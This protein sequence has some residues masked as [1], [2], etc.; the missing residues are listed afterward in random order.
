MNQR[1]ALI[2]DDDVERHLHFRKI[3]ERKGWAYPHVATTVF[4]ASRRLSTCKYQ[5]V[6]LDHDLGY[7]DS[8]ATGMSLVQ[9][10]VG[11]V[12][13]GKRRFSGTTFIVH[14]MNPVGAQNM[15]RALTSVGLNVKRIPLVQL[16]DAL[17]AA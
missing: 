17:R 15:V 6:F 10:I 7:T 12:Q 16:Y 5:Q 4:E 11:Q 2:L 9:W 8:K 1:F 3:F 14:S 13:A